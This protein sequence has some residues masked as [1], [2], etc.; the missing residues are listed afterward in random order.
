MYH[1][2]FDD[3]IV[4]VFGILV[5]AFF[6]G[7]TSCRQFFTGKS[8]D[9]TGR[10][11]P[12]PP[13]TPSL[14]A[15]YEHGLYPPN[16][17]ADPAAQHSK[18]R[19]SGKMS[20]EELEKIRD[21]SAAQQSDVK[22][23]NSAT[24]RESAID[25]AQGYV[26]VLAATVDIPGLK[27]LPIYLQIVSETDVKIG[28]KEEN[29]TPRSG[30]NKDSAHSD[31]MYHSYE[32]VGVD[33]PPNKTPRSAINSIGKDSAHSDSLYHSYENVGMDPPSIGPEPDVD[34]ENV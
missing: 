13:P 4:G 14:V 21:L 7:C 10:R 17:S 25:E 12:P 18:L 32:N 16:S 28:D 6:I 22:E 30:T 20:G 1:P 11:Q 2:S 19:E 5:M 3:L 8:S 34:Y 33:P 23:Q 27:D 15:R 9:S 26:N 29:K 24:S 31:S